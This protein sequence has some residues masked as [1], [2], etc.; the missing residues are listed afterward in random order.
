M[1]RLV[2]K[3]GSTKVRFYLHQVVEFLREKKQENQDL[4]MT[5]EENQTKIVAETT[6]RLKSN[7]QLSHRWSRKEAICH[8]D[9]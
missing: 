1:V 3:F 6:K 9:A 7:S 8:A 5:T 2:L 4:R